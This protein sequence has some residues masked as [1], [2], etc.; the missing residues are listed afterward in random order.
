MKRT[1]RDALGSDEAADDQ[2][3]TMSSEHG[4]QAISLPPPDDFHHHFRDGEVLP[5]TVLHAASQ[6]RRCIAMPNLKPPVVT[7]EDAMRYR[8]RILSHVP[9]GVDFQPLMTLYLTDNTTPKESG[10]VYAVKLYPAGAT[11]NSSAGVTDMGKVQDTLAEMARVG[12]LLLI[13]GE[14]TDA[15]CDIFEKEAAFVETV[16]TPLVQ[17]HPTLRIVLE[18]MTTEEAVTFVREAPPNVAGSITVQHL[19]YNRNALF[20]GGIRPHMYC[21]PILKHERHRLALLEAATSGNPKFFAGT[22]SAPHAIGSKLC[23]CGCAGIFSAHAAVALYAEAFDDMGKLEH[24]EAF[25][26]RNGADHYGLPRNEGPGIVLKKEAWTVPAS[27]EFGAS[28]VVP[29]RASEEISWAVQGKG[30]LDVAS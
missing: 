19:L 7:T 2:A 24:L 23:A 12:L 26:C 14:V 30:L 1:L 18:H 4:T 3:A 15:H 16:L 9:E 5:N 20:K 21:L 28:V 10:I 6:F 17:Q 13:H 8:E 29:L 22:D 27:Y 25:L 11:T